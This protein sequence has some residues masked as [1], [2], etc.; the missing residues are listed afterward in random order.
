MLCPVFACGVPMSVAAPSPTPRPRPALPALRLEL[1]SRRPWPSALASLCAHGAVI[2]GLLIEGRAALRHGAVPGGGGGGGGGGGADRPVINFF[3]VPAGA[4]PAVVDV[5][6]A[7]RVT[8]T[9]LPALQQ[10]RLDL[11]SVAAPQPDLRAGLRTVA[12]AAVGGGQGP[13]AGGGAGAGAGPGAGGAAGPGT[14]DE[15]GYILPA[16]LRT[17]VMP[18]LSNVPGS[19]LGR[20]YRVRF[21]VSAHGRGT[22]VEWD[23]PITDA[24]YSREFQQRMMAV[25]SYPAHTRD[26]QNVASVVTVGVTVPRRVGN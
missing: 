4:A 1:P 3:P 26:G 11:P 6:Q 19:V 13:G 9:A 5:P 10:I 7:P 20:T 12:A 2:A 14:G 23:P 24:D 22:R 25:R 8:I 21:W 17:A 15:G 16:S 18:P